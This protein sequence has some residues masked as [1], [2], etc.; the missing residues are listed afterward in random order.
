[1]SLGYVAALIIFAVGGAMLI[2]G[3]YPMVFDEKTDNCLTYALRTWRFWLPSDHLN[4][5]VSHWGWFPHFAVIFELPDGSL[6]KKEYVPIHP[7]RRWIPPLFFKGR[8]VTTIY[9]L[10]SVETT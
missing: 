5:R 6:V 2:Y 3:L 7:R 8:E 4:I 1:M 9:R 10:E